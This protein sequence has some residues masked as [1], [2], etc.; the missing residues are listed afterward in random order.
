MQLHIEEVAVSFEG[1]GA[2]G[3]DALIYN[4]EAD[5]WGSPSSVDKVVYGPDVGEHDMTA[6][7]V[8]LQQ[9]MIPASALVNFFQT[10]GTNFG[11]FTPRPSLA[12][13]TRQNV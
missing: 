8:L 1:R 9:W 10:L 7:Q 6:M 13:E 2:D 11:K 12:R 3:C 4:C 5:E